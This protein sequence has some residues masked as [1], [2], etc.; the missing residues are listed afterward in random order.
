[1]TNPLL[2]CGVLFTLL[3]LFAAEA[4][5]ADYPAPAKL[6]EVRGLPDPF[7]FADGTRVKTRADWAKRRAELLA[8]ILHYE[9]G[10]MPPAPGNTA[11]VELVSHN[12][13]ELPGLIHKV[14]K[15]SCGPDKKVSFTLDL[16]IPKGK[17]PFPVILRGDLGWG[18]LSDEITAAIVGRGYILAEFNRT[19]LAPDNKGY[20]ETGVYQAYPEVQGSAVGAWAWGFHRC[21]DFL[22]TL[23][24]VDKDKIVAT[25]HSRGGKAVLLAGATSRRTSRSGSART[26]SNSSRP[27]PKT[28]RTASRCASA[29]SSACRSINMR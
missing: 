17:G 26:S 21:V 1:M 7:L 23:E 29:T 10:E 9:Y 3:V 28:A 13:K 8:Q 18:K 24:V 11:G 19:E 6:P 14:F 20:R 15:I 22:L 12:F 25:G 2:T 27:S 16:I 4:R 5:P